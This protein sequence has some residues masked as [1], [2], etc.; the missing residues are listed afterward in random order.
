MSIFPGLGRV[1]GSSPEMF[2]FVLMDMAKGSIKKIA[3]FPETEL[4]AW[5][6]EKI[7][8]EAMI[9]SIVEEARKNEV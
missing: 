9:D 1:K 2:I 5:L 6:G 8:N 7:D 3:F 4:R